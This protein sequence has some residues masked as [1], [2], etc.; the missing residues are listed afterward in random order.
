MK[1]DFTSED[2]KIVKGLAIILMLM[3]HLWTFSDRIIGDGLKYSIN[4][5]GQSSISYLGSFG[6]ICV[7]LFYFLGGY[8]IYKSCQGRKFDIVKKIKKL[9]ISYWKVFLIFIPVGFVFFSKQPFYCMDKDICIKFATFSW[10]ECLKNF[11]GLESTYNGEWWFLKSYVYAIISYPFIEKIVS[12]FSAVYNIFFV[13]IGTILVTNVLPTLGNIQLLG[14][15]NTNFLYNTL[16]CQ[17]APYVSSFWM[18]IVMAKDDLILELRSLLLE[19]KILNSLYDIVIL[20]FIV[21]MRTTG[22]GEY[23]DIFYVPFI[24]V[25][26]VDLV[27]KCKILQKIFRALGNEAT[28]MWLIHTFLCYYFY[29]I[30][31]II[32]YPQYAMLSLLELI[33]LSYLLSIIVKY[34]WKI[35]DDARRCIYK[36]ISVQFLSE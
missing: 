13:I 21:Y 15:L 23:L 20:I 34:I 29:Q 25:C 5:M 7:P 3:H 28:N 17:T 8:G 11:L 32:V 2:T 24:I 18:G 31:K 22:I 1:K 35:L 26:F 33:I 19:N 6:K 27:S 14:T 10:D 12:R 4:I 36:I 9:Y 16:I 30:A